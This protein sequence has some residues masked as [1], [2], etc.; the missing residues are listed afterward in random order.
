LQIRD[1]PEILGIVNYE[2]VV[3]IDVEVLVG[4]KFKEDV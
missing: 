3:L 4:H 2:F 1:L